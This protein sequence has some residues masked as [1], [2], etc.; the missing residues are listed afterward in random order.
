MATQF[1]ERKGS[2]FSLGSRLE[3][4]RST[5]QCPLYM[6]L[7]YT[8]NLSL[9]CLC[10]QI[11]S[12][13]EES[14]VRCQPSVRLVGT[15]GRNKRNSELYFAKLKVTRV[16][17]VAIAS[18]CTFVKTVIPA[19]TS[20]FWTSERTWTQQ[21]ETDSTCRALWTHGEIIHRSRSTGRPGLWELV[22]HL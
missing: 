18:N 2:G 12:L 21:C 22:R 16:D 14:V 1:P 5:A 8:N 9:F 4:K 7:S 15:H 10:I 20:W 3:R 17:Q 13:A 11:I 19:V 6:P